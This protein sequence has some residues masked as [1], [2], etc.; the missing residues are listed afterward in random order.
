[1]RVIQRVRELQ[2]YADAERA[3]GRRLALVPTMGA[4]H[5]GHLALVEAARRRADRVVV[6]IFVNPTQF[7]DPKDLAAYP[8]ALG[9]DLE[10]CERAGVDAVFAPEAGEMYPEGAQSFVEVTE[11]AKPL[12]GRTRP[13][14]FRGVATVVT[15]LFCAAKPHV[16]VFGEKDWQQL[17][18][19]RRM[20]R[21]LLLDVEIVGV[22]TLREADGLAMSSRNRNLDA[23]A[24][25]QARVLSQALDAAEGAVRAGERD[26][27][28]LLDGVRRELAKAPRAE[29]DYAELRDPHSLAPAPAALDGPTLLA[30]AVFLRP[31][32]GGAGTPVRLIDNRVLPVP[33][34]QETPR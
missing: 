8:R 13:G 12:C 24:R 22:P 14:H 23:D 10:S 17:A 7:N 30:L 2:D 25:G 4:L 1:M 34:R 28:R 31:P 19:I 11:L 20:A 18:L 26:A 3:A 29:V 15:K 6:S 5:A 27:A 32:E 9:E 16:A 33:P 21:D